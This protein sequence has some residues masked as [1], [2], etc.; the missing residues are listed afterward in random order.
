M[1]HVLII[2]DSSLRV[3]TVPGEPALLDFIEIHSVSHAIRLLKPY[4]HDPVAMARLRMLLAQDAVATTPA[5]LAEDQVIRLLAQRLLAGRI[6]IARPDQP[7]FA[8][9][10]ATPE[11][12]TP[13]E[14]KAIKKKLTW[15]EILVINDLTGQPVPWVRMAVKLPSGEENFYTTDNEGLIRVEDIEPGTCDA[16]CDLKNATLDDTF[17]F[18]AMGEKTDPPRFPSDA[19]PSDNTIRRIAEIEAHKVK[20][21]ET[22]DSLAQKAGM[23]WQDLA[24]F[25]WNADYPD[26]INQALHN[27]VGCTKKT[28]D[29][30]NYVFDDTDKPG[31]VYI[32][33]KW[34]ETGL[35]TGKQHVVRAKPVWRF[36]LI[37]QNE[38]EL[39]IPEVDYEATFSDDSRKSGKLGIGGM[40]HLLEPVPG[41]I[42]VKYKDHTDILQ[43][44]LAAMARDAFER[45]DTQE[46]LRV[47]KHDPKTVQGMIDM[48]AK[49]YNDL[50][51]QGFVED[52]YAEITDD[53]AVGRME[54]LM[55]L[56][57]LK[58]RSGKTLTLGSP[59]DQV[60]D[61]HGVSAP[62][63]APPAYPSLPPPPATD[64][65]VTTNG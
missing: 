5:S 3:L 10:E 62:T 9:I 46:I 35:A 7:R 38:R 44:S 34:E 51:G 16:R 65:G 45:R 15:I 59:P 32:P 17:A 43:K 29:R 20:A 48:Y 56:A 53:E 49:Y 36:F 63:A 11:E 58:V 12:A 54:T 21:G 13:D 18:V 57:E 28:H 31:I 40:D 22:L 27:R 61:E 42:D 26:A 1:R 4:E 14:G 19:F 64:E 41:T 60:Y 24:R 2:T 23:K 52:A 50:S 6:H 8:I 33:T 30:L 39:R 55:L 25:N 37:L 47:L